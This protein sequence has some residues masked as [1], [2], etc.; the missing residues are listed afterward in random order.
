MFSG[1]VS[2]SFGTS[3]GVRCQLIVIVIQKLLELVSI[4]LQ[5]RKNEIVSQALDAKNMGFQHANG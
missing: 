4:E 1:I 3:S 2:S 5:S